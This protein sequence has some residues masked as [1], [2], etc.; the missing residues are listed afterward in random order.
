MIYVSGSGA[1]T[2]MF[3]GVSAGGTDA[4]TGGEAN[5]GFGYQSAIAMTAVIIIHYRVMTGKALT[6]GTLTY[7]R[8][9]AGVKNYCW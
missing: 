4:A 5:I 8:K 7:S 3:F 2:S 9:S 6:V 1:N